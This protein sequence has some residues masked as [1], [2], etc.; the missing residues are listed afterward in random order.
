MCYG[1]VLA[2]G[3]SRK[4]GESSYLNWMKNMDMFRKHK[5]GLRLL[6][7]ISNQFIA[8]LPL[9]QLLTEPY[10]S[11]ILIW[12]DGWSYRLHHNGSGLRATN[13]IFL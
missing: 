8:D 1:E 13:C 9:R 5:V 10:S 7:Y 2:V 11:L 3:E 12:Q 6:L 4:A